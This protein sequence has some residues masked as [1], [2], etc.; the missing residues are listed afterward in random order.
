MV[1]KYTTPKNH[2]MAFPFLFP[3]EWLFPSAPPQHPISMQ[4]NRVSLDWHIRSSIAKPT[5][6]ENRPLS[7]YSLCD[8]I[9]T[10]AIFAF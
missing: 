3:G 1:S 4:I 2:Q 5:I 7:L 8:L 9:L 10:F 6:T